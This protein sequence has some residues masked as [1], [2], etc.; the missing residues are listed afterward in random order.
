MYPEGF[1]PKLLTIGLNST[2]KAIRSKNVERVFLAS[3]ADP[4]LCDLIRELAGNDKIPIDESCT[5]EQLG[6]FCGIE[7]PC[8]VC[9]ILTYK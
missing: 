1:N 2:K 7:V 4:R 3:D 5:M 8:A 6:S 9:A